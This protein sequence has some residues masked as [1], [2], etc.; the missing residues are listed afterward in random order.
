MLGCEVEVRVSRSV[1]MYL[2]N[3]SNAVF[4]VLYVLTVGCTTGPSFESYV[5]KLLDRA[6]DNATDCGVARLSEPRSP[7]V[8]CG[9]EALSSRAPFVAIF[10]VQGIDSHIFTGVAVNAAGEAFRLRWDSDVTGGSRRAESRKI[11]E[12]RCSVLKLA[13]SARPVECTSTGPAAN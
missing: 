9:Q 3:P 10:E 5:A 7:V 1:V 2:R 11:F 12:E 8:E 13:D 6:G 4:A